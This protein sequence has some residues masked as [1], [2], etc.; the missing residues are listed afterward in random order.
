MQ[1]E[2]LLVLLHLHPWRHCHLQQQRC[3]LYTSGGKLK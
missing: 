2:L 1:Q 3:M